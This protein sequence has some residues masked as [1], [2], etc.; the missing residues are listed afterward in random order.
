MKGVPDT[1]RPKAQMVPPKAAAPP[2]QY[3]QAD[4]QETLE[5]IRRQ[6]ELDQRDVA[7]AN[8]VA[9][10]LDQKY[11]ITDWTHPCLFLNGVQTSVTEYYPE[12]KVAI[13]KFYHVG[14]WEQKITDMKKALLKKEGIRYAFL[15]PEKTLA[16]IEADLEA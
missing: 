5:R 10:I 4:D 14:A 1:N 13:D 8:K 2:D 12:I 7:K 9:R 3:A 15:T 6:N 16:D 11:Y